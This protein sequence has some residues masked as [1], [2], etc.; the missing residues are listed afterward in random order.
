[1]NT[2]S[3]ILSDGE[4]AALARDKEM[5]IPYTSTKVRTHSGKRIISYGQNSYGYDVTLS[6]EFVK[7][8][9]RTVIDP[10]GDIDSIRFNVSKGYFDLEPY[11]SILAKTNEYVQMPSDVTGIVLGKST[12]CRCGLLVNAT[13]LEAGW[14]GEITLELH[15]L[16]PMPIRL[17][18]DEGIAQILFFKGAVPPKEIYNGAYQFQTGV[19]LPFGV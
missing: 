18:V 15:N 7:F 8:V 16:Q 11:S 17:Y 3:S 2:S 14:C 13:P 1:M 5:I 10:K 6:D 12:Y 4:I 19:T 9:G